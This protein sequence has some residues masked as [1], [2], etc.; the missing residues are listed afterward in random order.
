LKDL[1][2][3]P[4]RGQQ[5]IRLVFDQPQTLRR[6][7]LEFSESECERTQEFTLRWSDAPQGTFREIAR[8]QYN[9]SPRGSTRE[10]EDY[11]VRLNNVSVL[12][13]T[14]KPELN[15]GSGIA[16]LSRLHVA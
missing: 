14:I 1:A 10:I 12:E 6:I 5:T 11:Q 16:T 9:F 7:W 2:G 8:Q 13:L 4:Q 15:A 3:A